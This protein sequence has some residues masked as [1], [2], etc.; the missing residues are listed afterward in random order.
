MPR[1]HVGPHSRRP[2]ID[3]VELSTVPA[4]YKWD[5]AKNEIQCELED[6][7]QMKNIPMRRF[8]RWTD[9]HYRKLCSDEEG[10][11]VE[12][13]TIRDKSKTER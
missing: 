6:I 12:T 2:L 13:Q 11:I 10:D 4:N 3:T 7:K 9:D 5:K 1:N 8:A